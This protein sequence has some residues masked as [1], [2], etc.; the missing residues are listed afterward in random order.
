M[1]YLFLTC[2]WHSYS[3]GVFNNQY[4]GARLAL[5]QIFAGCV[6]NCKSFARVCCLI[7]TFIRYSKWW[8]ALELIKNFALGLYRCWNW[9]SFY[10]SNNDKKLSFWVYLQIEDYLFTG[11]SQV[12]FYFM[13][14]GV[15]Y[16][17][18]I[19][20]MDLHAFGMQL[21]TG[22]LLQRWAWDVFLSARVPDQLEKWYYSSGG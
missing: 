18:Q 13:R 14:F 3:A 15:R 12:H 5:A 1:Q 21:V 2:L 4:T 7:K 8:C 6:M 17:L 22:L 10:Y 20:W 9:L 16:A 11:E 19:C